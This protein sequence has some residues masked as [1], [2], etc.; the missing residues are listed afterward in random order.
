MKILPLPPLASA[1]ILLWLAVIVGG[2]ELWYTSNEKKF[3][4]TPLEVIWPAALSGCKELVVPE[5]VRQFLL[6]SSGRMATW[7]D[8]CEWSLFTFRWSPGRTAT[9]S[10]RMHRPDTCFQASGAVQPVTVAMGPANL[11]FKSYL[12]CLSGQQLFVFFTIWEEANLDGQSRALGQDWSGWSR[13]QR[14]FA[15][16]RNLGQQSLEFVISGPENYEEAFDLFKAR[17]PKLVRCR[18]VETTLFKNRP[19]RLKGQGFNHINANSYLTSC[20]SLPYQRGSRN[21]CPPGAL[22]FWLRYSA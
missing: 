21:P 11:R 7:R 3:Q 14:A 22:A 15:R 10:A 12:F 16:Q 4:H 1:T 9:Q 18:A 6:S 2:T 8:G 20:S 13:V 17:L 19:T 5:N